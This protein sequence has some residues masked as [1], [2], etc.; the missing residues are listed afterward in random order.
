[1]FP[2]VVPIDGNGAFLW[3]I[4]VEIVSQCFVLLAIELLQVTSMY[5]HIY[6][7][8]IVDLRGCNGRQTGLLYSTWQMLCQTLCRFRYSL[9][10][11]FNN[12]VFVLLLWDTNL[13]L[14]DFCIKTRIQCN[15]MWHIFF[16]LQIFNSRVIQVKL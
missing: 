16:V 1:M 12:L 6:F 3:Y 5:L 8:C 7:R 15:L 4:C 9:R 14:C 13:H 2:K 11:S 10:E